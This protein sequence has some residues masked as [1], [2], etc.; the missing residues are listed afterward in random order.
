MP[1]VEVEIEVWC[2]RCG[3]GICN[4]AEGTHKGLVVEPCDR[5]IDEAK[6]DAYNDGLEDGRE[7]VEK[8]KE[9]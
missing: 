4:L 3:T 9:L 7:E 8:E 2:A 1:K 5:C 6:E